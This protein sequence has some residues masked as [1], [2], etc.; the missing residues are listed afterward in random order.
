MNSPPIV[1]PKQGVARVQS[2]LSGDTVILLGKSTNP[3]Q[4][5]P[6]VTF[7]LSAV[8]APVRAR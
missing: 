3:N 1:L 4:P 7:T 5:P 6:T 8:S 2:V